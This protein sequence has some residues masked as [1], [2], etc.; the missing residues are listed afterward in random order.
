MCYVLQVIIKGLKK[1]REQ[2]K[3]FSYKSMKCLRYSQKK[4]FMM[5]KKVHSQCKSLFYSFKKTWYRRTLHQDS[6]E[7]K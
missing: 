6:K 5:F 1:L 7:L 4:T 3:I 2:E